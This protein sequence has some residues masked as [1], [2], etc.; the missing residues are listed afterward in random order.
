MGRAW[1]G[2]VRL[3]EVPATSHVLIWV[4]VCVGEFQFT[5]TKLSSM[6]TSIKAEKT[7]KEQ[8]VILRFSRRT[9][10]RLTHG[11]FHCWNNN[12]KIK[13]TVNVR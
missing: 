5:I 11:L 12:I 1:L 6:C 10:N 3:L 4:V 9:F 7:K 13:I 2:C 8:Y